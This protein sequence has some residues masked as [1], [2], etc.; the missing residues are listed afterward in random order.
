VGL[1]D[2]EERRKIALA[3]TM[4]HCLERMLPHEI[5]DGERRMGRLS[6]IERETDVLEAKCEAEARRIEAPLA[7]GAAISVHKR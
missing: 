7:E 1:H 5:S 4:R 2:A 6:E 3:L